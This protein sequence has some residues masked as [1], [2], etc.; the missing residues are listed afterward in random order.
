MTATSPRPNLRQQAKMRTR[1]KVLDAARKLLSEGG[2]AACTIRD[3][4]ALAGMST[5]AVFAN[6]KD[7]DDLIDAVLV[8]EIQGLSEEMRAAAE[9]G[10]QVDQRLVSV[11][12]TVADRSQHR[13]SLLRAAISQVCAGRP[14]ADRIREALRE[15]V[16]VLSGVLEDGARKGE[17]SDRLDASG[18]AEWI[19]DGCQAQMRRAADHNLPREV[20]QQRL[21]QA[22]QLLLTGARAL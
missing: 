5:G 9:Q 16:S 13:L 3:V 8:E 17:L 6:F 21:D 20:V 1:A 4:A 7:K 14:D 15:P 19:W 12:H 18:A 2:Y 22:A 11:L 10:E